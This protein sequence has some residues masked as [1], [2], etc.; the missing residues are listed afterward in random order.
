MDLSGLH[1]HAKRHGSWQM[2]ISAT[3]KLKCS[4]RN[5]GHIGDK[6]HFAYLLNGKHITEQEADSLLMAAFEQ[7]MAS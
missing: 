2:Q 4:Y 3:Q 6:W 7:R 1:E 5:G